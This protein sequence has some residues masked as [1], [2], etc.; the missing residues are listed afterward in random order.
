MRVRAEKLGGKTWVD[1]VVPRVKWVIPTTI[2]NSH[3]L[4]RPN[5]G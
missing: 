4:L 2:S 5:A 1:L 3:N